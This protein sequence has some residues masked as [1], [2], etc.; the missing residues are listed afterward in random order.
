MVQ[1]RPGSQHFQ[2]QANPK[3]DCHWK[4]GSFWTQTWNRP[5]VQFRS[6]PH[7]RPDHSIPRIGHHNT[8]SVHWSWAFAYVLVTTCF[9]EIIAHHFAQCFGNV[10]LFVQ[11]RSCDWLYNIESKYFSKT[12]LQIGAPHTT[13]TTRLRFPWLDQDKDGNTISPCTYPPQCN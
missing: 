7:S 9:I 1:F 11:Y 8:I 5:Q 10:I 12:K 4:L 13:T 2:H 6:K 3:P